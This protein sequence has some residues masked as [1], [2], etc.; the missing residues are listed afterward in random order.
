MEENNN[1]GGGDDDNDGNIVDALREHIISNGVINDLRGDIARGYQAL[2]LIST[3]A[4]V[5][6]KS[7]LLNEIKILQSIVYD[8]EASIRGLPEE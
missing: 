5:G 4:Q 7:G 8:I 3:S 2:N 6:R 1:G